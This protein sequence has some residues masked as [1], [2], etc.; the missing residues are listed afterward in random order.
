MYDFF[1]PA[2]KIAFLYM[3]ILYILMP[4]LYC[5]LVWKYHCITLLYLS[6]FAFHLEQPAHVDCNKSA[7]INSI[8]IFLIANHHLS[9][10]SGPQ[11][12]QLLLKKGVSTVIQ[13]VKVQNVV[14]LVS[15]ILLLACTCHNIYFNIMFWLFFLPA[16]PPG[17]VQTCQRR[18]RHQHA[19]NASSS[20]CGS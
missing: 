9:P 13:R 6:H 16:F 1:I 11:V 19:P 10:V 18:R 2:C 8:F 20:H 14:V 3:D 15:N 4:F 17:S 7:F 12:L 5:G